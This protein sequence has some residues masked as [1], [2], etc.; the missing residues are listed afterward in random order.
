MDPE[1]LRRLSENWQAEARER[2]TALHREE[3]GKLRQLSEDALVTRHDEC[4]R[5]ARET[6]KQE[7]QRDYLDRA[8]AYAAELVR[9]EGTKQ[10]DRM[11]ALTSSLNRLTWWIVGFTVLIAI[12]TVVGLSLT[13]WTLLSG[14]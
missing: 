7:V 4:L 12:A 6:G 1:Q 9:R 5:A 13:A 11:E 10:A 8:K 14:S 2:A 3:L